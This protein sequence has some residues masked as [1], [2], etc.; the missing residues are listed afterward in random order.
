MFLAALLKSKQQHKP[1]CHPE[2][3][4]ESKRRARPRSPMYN[5]PVHRL[6]LTA[7]LL[8][9][10]SAHAATVTTFDFA[11][12]D[13][14][15]WE[16][17]GWPPPK[18]STQGLQIA[19]DKDG[20]MVTTF[21]APPKPHTLVLRTKTNKAT[22]A[23]ILWDEDNTHTNMVQLP[24]VIPASATAHET[25]I[26][27]TRYPQWYVGT[28]RLGLALPAGADV[29]VVTME[30][31]R[32]SPMERLQWATKSVLTFD[33][34]QSFS[35]NF[36]WG[37]LIAFTP[38]EYAH[39]FEGQPPSSWSGMRVTYVVLA[40]AGL[41][42]LV[43]RKHALRIITVSVAA[44]WLI[45]DLRMSAE[46]VAYAVRDWRTQLLPP[47]QERTFRDRLFF[48][49]MLEQSDALLRKDPQF[50]LLSPHPVLG[51]VRYATLPSVPVKE[52]DATDALKRWLVFDDVS[53]RVDGEGRLTKNGKVLSRPG[54]VTLRFDE[55]SFLFE[56][57]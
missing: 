54:T 14:V 33:M 47:V 10:V 8:L 41:C 3:A 43:R 53:A 2:L 16:I 15:R 36:V 9:P 49:S 12:N 48:A 6:L 13:H 46:L 7:A 4:E 31:I 11:N 39:L 19:T 38:E 26:D 50:G 21:E 22:D 28:R 20:A 37:P 51:H 24:L 29:T 40:I 42:A 35:I 17:Q 27:L 18:K 25:R 1:K 52:A 45:L 57:P 5:A 30:I 44:V 32:Y 34:L 23:L 55:H 56:T